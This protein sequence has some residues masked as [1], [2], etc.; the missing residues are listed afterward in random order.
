ML[1]RQGR[2]VLK[3]WA[4]HTLESNHRDGGP[5][6]PIVHGAPSVPR[7]RVSAVPGYS[8]EYTCGERG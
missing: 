1:S 4:T 8:R 7:D 6:P 2:V 3:S 5:T